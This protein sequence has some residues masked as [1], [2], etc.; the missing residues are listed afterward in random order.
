[1][2][3]EPNEHHAWLRRMIGAWTYQMHWE[4]DPSGD[5]GTHAG[6]EV[7]RAFGDFWVMG[8]AEGECGGVMMT[9]LIALGF[10]PNRQ[11][12]DGGPGGRYV[13]TFMASVMPGMFVYEG[14]REGDM[15]TLDTVG[16]AMDDTSRS[17]RYRDVIEF[18]SDDVRT[19]SSHVLKDDGSWMRF[20]RGEYRREG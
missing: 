11:T 18:E 4:G 2:F 10:E 14:T 1:M 13:G 3:G 7:V 20:M 12:D 5:P 15:L 8:E 16:P 17:V 19:M 6:R 9:T